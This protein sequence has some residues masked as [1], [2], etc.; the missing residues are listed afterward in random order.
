M[1]KKPPKAWPWILLGFVCL[2]AARSPHSSGRPGNILDAD[3]PVVPALLATLG[4]VSA[5]CGWRARRRRGRWGLGALLLVAFCFGVAIFS[6]YMA[7]DHRL[8]PRYQ[9]ARLTGVDGC[10]E[11]PTR[12]TAEGLPVGTLPDTLVQQLT[13]APPSGSS[14][15][16]TVSAA[17]SWLR[18]MVSTT[19]STPTSRR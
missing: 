12:S 5:I 19:A 18:S 11:A 2:L 1:D 4:A 15:S 9:Y 10:A 17:G 13:A 14:M 8:N 7:I 6:S 16:R 3:V